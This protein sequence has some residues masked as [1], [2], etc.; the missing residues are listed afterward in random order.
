MTDAAQ[1]G[2]IGDEQ[3]SWIETRVTG[4]ASVAFWWRVSSEQDYDF[5]VFELDSVGLRKISGQ[6]DWTHETVTLEAGEHVLRWK[7]QKDRNTP[8]GDDA[9]WLDQLEI[10]PIETSQP[11]ITNVQLDAASI[12]ATIQSLPAAGS[13]ILECSTN[14]TD[15]SAVATNQIT[16]ANMS[17]VRPTTNNTQFLR[18]RV[19]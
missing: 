12:N 16:G 3:F 4:P 18:I 13:A 19:Q 5:L 6:T 2:G 17:I 10:T 14:L 8:A 7:Y 11:Q 9:G 15:W 1:S